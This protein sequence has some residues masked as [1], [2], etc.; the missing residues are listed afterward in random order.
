MNPK[1]ALCALLALTACASAPKDFGE[2]DRAATKPLRDAY[3]ECLGNA[4]ATFIAGSDDVAFLS[5]H[6]VSVC[7]QHL[8]PIEEYLSK[9]GFSRLYTAAFV[10]Q[11]RDSAKQMVASFV[12][13]EK[14]ASRPI[15]T[16]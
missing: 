7:E 15:G 14:G 4:T 11:M 16:P 13:K 8:A 3:D 9:N 5:R 10:D 6:I 2:S 12:L 1:Y